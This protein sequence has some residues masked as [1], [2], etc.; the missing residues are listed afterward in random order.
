MQADIAKEESLAKGLTAMSKVV[1]G[2]QKE[3]AKAQLDGSQ[4]M[5]KFLLTSPTKRSLSLT[6]GLRFLQI[7]RLT[8]IVEYMQHVADEKRKNPEAAKGTKVRFLSL[9]PSSRFS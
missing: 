3:A 1:K 6:L 5:V 4:K 7:T 9:S 2:Q 8:E